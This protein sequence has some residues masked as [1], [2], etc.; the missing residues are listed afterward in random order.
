[1]C[2]IQRTKA[3]WN[4]I[5]IPIGI[6][7]DKIITDF[8]GKESTFSVIKPFLLNLLLPKYTLYICVE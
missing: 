3:G 2:H 5:L 6:T 7:F 1:M 8:V 4:N